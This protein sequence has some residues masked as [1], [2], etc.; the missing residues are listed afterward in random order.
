MKRK[1][2]LFTSV[3]LLLSLSVSGEVIVKEI[4]KKIPTYYI[5]PDDP[6]PSLWNLRI[7]PYPMQTDITRK[8]VMEKYRVVVMENDYIK[9]LILPDVGGRIL[10]ALDKTN[11]DFDFIYHNHVIKP[12]L[13]ALRGAWLSGGIEWNFPTLGHT[14]NT[15]SPVKYKILKNSDGSVTCVVGTEEWVR[16]MKWE[17]FI[18]LFPDKSFF[19]TRIKLFN[20][21]LTHNNSYFWVNAATHAWKNTRVV[22]PPAEY[23]YAGGRRNP[24]PWPVYNGKDVSWYKNTPSA[25]DY[26]CGT[27]GDYNG[28]YNYERENGTAHYASRFESPGKKFWT[29]GT[30]RSGGIWEDLLTDEDG[31]YIEVQAGRLLTQGDTWIFEPHLMEQWDEW[32]YPVK[33]MHGFV[34]ANPDAA[35]NFELRDEEIFIALNTTRTFKDAE[36]KVYCGKD[37]IF[38]EKLDVSPLGFYRKEISLKDKSREYTLKFL[39]KDGREIIDYTTEKPDVLS[40][41]LQPDFSREKKN[42]AEAIFLQGYYSLKHWNAEGAIFSFK[43]AL[44]VDSEFTPAMKWLGILYYKTGKTKEALVLFENVL[45]RNEDDHTARYYRALSKV[46]LGIRDHIWED[47]YMVS[48]RAAYR[49]VAPYVLAALALEQQDYRKGRELLKAA[50]RNNPDDI[51]AKVLLVAVERHLDNKKEAEAIFKTVLEENPIDSLALIEKKLLFGKSELEVLRADPE[52]YLEAAADYSEMNLIDDAIRVL[53]FYC[54]NSSTKEY[55]VVYYYLGFF[56]DKLG[57]NKEAEKY[58]KKAS[59]CRPDFVFPFRVETEN[60]LKLALKYSPSDWKVH[61]YLGNLLTTK[62]RWKEGFECFK[63]AAE[64]SPEFPVLYRN[65]GEIY[66]K[67]IKDYEKAEKMYKK[68]VS[69]SSENFRLYVALDELYAINKKHSER[70]NLY[71]EAPQK[72]KE[73]FNYVLQRAQYYV[74]TEKYTKALEIL[75]THTFLPWEGWTGAREVLVLALLRRAYSYIEKGKY[76]NA[77]KDINAAMEYPENLGTGRPPDPVFAR[78]YYVI[79]LSYEKMGDK[80]LAE[81]YYNKVEKQ[82]TGMP[83]VHSYYRALALRKLGREKEAEGLLKELKARSE[84]LIEQNRRERPQY[85][86]WA[87]LACHALGE[88]SKAREYLQKV[89]EVAPSYRWASLFAFESKLLE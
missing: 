45:K 40:P 59:A 66:W 52:Y 63:K 68:A 37:K 39:D 87:S 56:N 49:H 19:K 34:K 84:S 29:W 6:S 25:H 32:W 4:E 48:R 54:E 35:V 8:K 85:Y 36:I 14:V 89:T 72:I 76:K 46:R 61:Y 43:K 58:F 12:G 75:R 79:G 21:T 9:L 22:F 78:E 82:R 65:L 51:K 33:K 2:L 86:L 60:V 41:E 7:Y 38:S 83:S 44:E 69:F 17:V 15:F 64:F 71:R 53:K 1:V 47:L 73:N 30:A 88:K 5:G 3:I 31:Q 10:A 28:A 80:K 74:D 13:V 20:R 81:K 11:N 42:S 26:F 16:R 23:T 67:K 77:I 70:W 55:P 27:P 62:L 57:L 50:I 24:R 18:D